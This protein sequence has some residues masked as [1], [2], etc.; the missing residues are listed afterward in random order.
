MKLTAREVIDIL[1]LTPHPEE[2]GFF[3]ETH[4]SAEVLDANVLPRITSYN[5]CYTKLL[6]STQNFSTIW[7]YFGFSNQALAALVL[8]TSAVYLAQRGKLHSYNFV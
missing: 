1:G 6:R 4:R 2:G 5:V 7:R 3:S 8:W